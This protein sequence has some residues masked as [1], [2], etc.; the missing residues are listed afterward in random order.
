M[1]STSHHFTVGEVCDLLT[2]EGEDHEFVFPD[3]DDDFDVGERE[4]EWDPLDRE[5]GK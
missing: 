3:S 2:G 1:A 5:Q 4:Y